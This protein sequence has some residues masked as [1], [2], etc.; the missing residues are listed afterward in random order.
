MGF[1]KEHAEDVAARGFGDSDKTICDQHLHEQALKDVIVGVAC[2]VSCSYCDRV[3]SEDDPI[4][5]SL[6]DV[7]DVVMDGVRFRF[8]RANDEGVSLDGGEWV[9]ANIYDSSDVL[10][11]VL[12]WDGLVDDEV[13]ED[14]K[15]TIVPDDWASRDFAV[16]NPDD[17]LRVNWAA[18]CKLVKHESRFTFMTSRK[19][20]SYDPDELSTVELFERLAKVVRRIPNA[21]AEI[22]GDEVLYRGRMTA[23]IP[24]LTTYTGAKLGSPPEGSASANRMSPAGIS[25]FYGGSDV[26]TVIAE[27]AAHSGHRYAVVVGF[28]VTRPIQIVDLTALPDLPSIFTSQ[29]RRTYYDISFLHD[30]RDEL[31][32]PVILDGREHIEY[33]PTQ[34]FTEYLRLSAPFTVEGLRFPSAQ[35][36]GK[37]CVLFCG[38]EACAEASAVES[39]TWLEYQPA[40]LSA[41]RVVAHGTRL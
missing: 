20:S 40:T 1:A 5:A 25:M 33:V 9:G 38:P 22:A 30:F 36:G 32:R 18:F 37:N 7:M 27:I 2:E 10:D 29:G 11:E 19:N 35:T 15:D 41:Y 24:D 12:G 14:M 17:Q 16:L 6:E 4:A 23:D 31:T 34:I 39:K 26:D 8:G 3:G 28:R 21:R 13:L